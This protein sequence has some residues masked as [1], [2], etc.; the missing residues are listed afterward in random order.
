MVINRFGQEKNCLLGGPTDIVVIFKNIFFVQNLHIF[1][2]LY[3]DYLKF[4][5][6]G[7]KMSS[8]SGKTHVVLCVISVFVIIIIYIL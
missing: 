1:C 2:I 7:H 4:D 5:G 3:M 6:C 8:N